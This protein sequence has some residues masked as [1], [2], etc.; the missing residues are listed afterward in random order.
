[1][2]KLHELLQLGE[3][4]FNKCATA[5]HELPTDDYIQF[6]ESFKPIP[7]WIFDYPSLIKD[8]EMFQSIPLQLLEESAK[9]IFG[10]WHI[11]KME[12]TPIHIG[13]DGKYAQIASITIGLQYGRPIY[14]AATEYCNHPSQLPLLTQKAVASAKKMAFR[15]LG[16]FFGRSLN[17]TLEMDWEQYDFNEP[18]IPQPTTEEER[19]RLLIKTC[20]TLEELSEL[21]SKIKV[22]DKVTYK[23]YADKVKE[24]SKSI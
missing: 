21:K 6:V 23:E 5:K 12:I 13:K 7:E 8:G 9:I 4:V 15:Q 20:A 10:Y 18:K 19:L 22:G 2:S 3:D 24:L 1:M 17:R 16:D 14:G 11:S